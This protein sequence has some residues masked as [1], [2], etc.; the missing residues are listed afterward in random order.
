MTRAR[1]AVLSSTLFAVACH[2]GASPGS[3]ESAPVSRPPYRLSPL[4]PE[5][6]CTD[7]VC[8]GGSCVAACTQGNV[9]ACYGD[10]LAPEP[11]DRSFD[12]ADLDRVAEA[13]SLGI[14]DACDVGELLRELCER[15]NPLPVCTA[16]YAA[17]QLS[18]VPVR[19]E[20]A[21]ID[22]G[23]IGC[24]AGSSDLPL[25]LGGSEAFLCIG[26]TKVLYATHRPDWQ[27]ARIPAVQRGSAAR[28]P[29]VADARA[30][31]L[32][33]LETSPPLA[34]DAFTTQVSLVLE[35]QSNGELLL[36]ELYREDRAAPR[37]DDAAPRQRFRPT[38]AV[39]LAV[40][41]REAAE[42]AA[43]CAEASR[44]LTA[45]AGDYGYDGE[46]PSTRRECEEAASVC[47]SLR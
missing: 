14:L 33:R 13:C 29:G 8:P 30:V 9:C 28:A 19:W 31:T 23:L 41:E 7:P 43:V 47:R 4:G 36:G 35:K 39:T 5:R 44:C 20:R 15:G 17:G 1:I 45:K 34:R 10:V 21:A 38:R 25:E 11:P 24:F 16:F 32:W 2:G 26:E 27:V 40:A 37:H 42:T 46:L 18:R 6:T 12:E 3:A 22:R